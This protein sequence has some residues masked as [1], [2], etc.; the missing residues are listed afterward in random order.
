[1][2]LHTNSRFMLTFVVAATAIAV[3]GSV[4]AMGSS[5]QSVTEETRIDVAAM[6]TG[7]DI[8]NLPILHIED[9]I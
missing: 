1:M 6:M 3:A 7:A 5:Q 4:W 9:P 8:A 2:T